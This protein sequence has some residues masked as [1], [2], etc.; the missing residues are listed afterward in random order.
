VKILGLSFHFVL[1]VTALSMAEQKLQKETGKLELPT[2]TIGSKETVV[3]SV[4][5]VDR[6]FAFENTL[7]EKWT[8]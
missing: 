1:V 7:K 4:V 3:K 6:H 5:L 2:R 8:S